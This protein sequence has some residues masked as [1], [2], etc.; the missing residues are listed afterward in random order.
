[1]K[2][3]LFFTVIALGLM[4]AGCSDNGMIND[5]NGSTV[6][7]AEIQDLSSGMSMSG[8]TIVDIAASDS[9]F[10]VLVEAVVFANLERVLDGKRQFTV[11]APTN[12]AFAKLLEGLG[13]EKE[14]LFVA[15]NKRLV[16]HILLYHVAPGERFA[17]DIL[18]SD[19]VRTLAKEFA[20]VKVE[21]GEPFIGNDKYGYAGIIQTDIDASNG[22]IHVLDAVMLPPK[23]KLDGMYDD[24]VEYPPDKPNMPGNTIVDVATGNSDFSLLVEAV[25]FADLVETLSGKRQFTVFA[26]TNEAFGNLLEGLGLEKEELFV[27]ENKELVEKILLYH[28]AP[29]RRYAEDVVESDRIRTMAKEFAFIKIEEDNVF[30]GNKKYGFGQ[31]I[32]TDIEASNG[33][34]HVLDT[35]IL[36]SSLE[37]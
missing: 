14:E 30:I 27:E 15:E 4:I 25:V 19:R 24:V 26:P 20:M 11:F 22:V 5:P 37:L 2:K 1:M 35:V 16:R 10:S 18:S 12:E 13:L 9:N 29:G 6:S 32:D 17:E 34:I 31:I 33:I 28:V 36:P 3:Y 8:S 23:L 7:D 21:D